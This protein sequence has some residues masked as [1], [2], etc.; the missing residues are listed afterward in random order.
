M[1]SNDITVNDT[2]K[3]LVLSPTDRMHALTLTDPGRPSQTVT[4]PLALHGAT[5]LLHVGTLTPDKWNSDTFKR[6]YL[7][8]ESLT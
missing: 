7:T 1:S 4:I 3:F 8:S 6:E 2:L 5:L